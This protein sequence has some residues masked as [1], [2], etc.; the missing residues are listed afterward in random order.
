MKAARYQ[1]RA[2]AVRTSGNK[3]LAHLIR[4]STSRA[5]NAWPP[6]PLGVYLRRPS[7]ENVF[8][9]AEPSCQLFALGRHA[10]WQ[11]VRALRITRGD[12]VLVPAYHHGSE[13]E[14]LVRT[15]A[16]CRFYS[17]TDTLEPD[18]AELAELVGSNTRALLL[19]H[20]LGFPQDASRWRRWCDERELL[21]IEDAA[22]AWLACAKGRPVG[23][24]GDASI[25]CLYK[26]F[27]LPDGA[28]LVS[29][30]RAHDASAA[31][32]R[33]TVRV[34]RRH[35]AWVR[36]RVPWQPGPAALSEKSP[37][38]LSDEFALGDPFSGPAAATVFLLPRVTAL[39]AS[40]RRRTNYR[41]FL[42]RFR[43]RVPRPFNELPPEASPFLFPIETARKDAMLRRLACAGVRAFD[44]WSQ[45]HPL[46]PTRRFAAADRRRARTVG[47][48]VHQELRPG[49]LESIAEVVSV[50]LDEDAG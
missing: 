40:E 6:L 25:F 49:D 15:G 46:V 37:L 9:L 33:G 50:A 35:A 44:F 8:P 34:L 41:F 48:P 1:E 36:G 11:G 12:E 39:A 31:S 43:E 27:G 30:P 29:T 23:S 42:N 38:S 28:A 47:L 32:P 5:L 24:T 2:T 19:T 26:T 45:G 4:G 21:L 13:V 14:A 16:V 18:E 7:G 22:Q 3:R 17:G 20:Y 10:L